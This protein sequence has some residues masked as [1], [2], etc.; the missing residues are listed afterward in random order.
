V[1]VQYR[2]TLAVFDASDLLSACG[3]VT[4]YYGIVE[5]GRLWALL[6]FLSSIKLVYMRAARVGGLACVYACGLH[7]CE[8]FAIRQV[9]FLVDGDVL[10]L[11]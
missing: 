9:V 11:L 5:C 2:Q 6:C 1:A 3:G 8:V 7:R 10:H 4:G